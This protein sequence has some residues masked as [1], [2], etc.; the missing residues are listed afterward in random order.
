MIQ[1]DA[2]LGGKRLTRKLFMLIP[3]SLS[4]LWKG[5]FDTF[6]KWVE[7]MVTAKQYRE[8]KLSRRYPYPSTGCFG[9]LAP[10]KGCLS[11]HFCCLRWHPCSGGVGGWSLRML[12]LCWSRVSPH[13]MQGSP[14]TFQILQSLTEPSITVFVASWLA[15]LHGNNRGLVLSCW[16]D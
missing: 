12:H 3:T 1:L 11:V 2:T 13:G 9:S 10:I 8:N 15:H 16:A 4:S 6:D 7:V 5:I 14:V